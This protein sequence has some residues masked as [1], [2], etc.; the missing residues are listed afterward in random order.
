MSGQAKKGV[1]AGK[2]VDVVSGIDPRKITALT[3]IRDKIKNWDGQ[4][5]GKIEDV[6]A[7]ARY[8]FYECIYP[9][10]AGIVPETRYREKDSFCKHG[11]AS[12]LLPTTGG[13]G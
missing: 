4:E 5:L 1:Q 11:P 9:V 2:T 7:G 3:V 13:A 6:V 12:W 8:L 10:A